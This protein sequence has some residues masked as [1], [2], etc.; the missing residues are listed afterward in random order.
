MAYNDEEY[1]KILTDIN[2]KIDT[3]TADSN[4]KSILIQSMKNAFDNKSS[5]EIE[6][7]EEFSAE[8]GILKSMLE[9]SS[10]TDDYQEFLNALKN[11]EQSFTNEI[12]NVAF[13]KKNMLQE[14]K[15]DIINVFE[16]TSYLEELYPN[17]SVEYLTEIK[18]MIS[19]S[20]ASV[21]RD[22]NGQIKTDFNS[23]VEAVGALYGN[24]QKFKGE[25]IA[26]SSSEASKL[27]ENLQ[28]VSANSSG[29]SVKLDELSEVLSQDA[30]DSKDILTILNTASG[31]IDEII[32][33]IKT[34]VENQISELNNNLSAVCSRFDS[35]LEDIK[36]SS[37]DNFSQVLEGIKTSNELIAQYKDTAS[38]LEDSLV[39][40]L[41]EF[42]E[43]ISQNNSKHT[44]ETTEKVNE[45][46]NL[47][48]D[49][50]NA[51]QTTVNPSESADF[52]NK[53]NGLETVLNENYSIYEKSLTALQEKIE[54]YIV[55]AE[56]VSS[57]ANSKLETSVLGLNEINKNLNEVYEKIK[58]SGLENSETIT[59]N[60]ADVISKFA[61]IVSVVEACKNGFDENVRTIMQDNVE[62][63]DKGLGY[64]S[65]NLKEIKDKQSENL[66]NV[67]EA[68]E[69]NITGIKEAF[70][71]V[72]SEVL[73]AVNEKSEM[74]LNEFEPVK[75]ALNKFV[76]SNFN[77]VVEDIKNQMQLSYLNLTSEL[78][79]K[80][81][82]N[83]DTFT[84]LENTYKDVVS[85][86]IALEA[87]LSSF[88]EKDLELMTSAI[89]SIDAGVKS[90]LDKSGKLYSEW[91]TF[92]ADF[93]TKIKEGMT[94]L[95]N[96]LS[97]NFRRFDKKLD[98][99]LLAKQKELYDYV[100]MISDN[101]SF[102]QLVEGANK[103]LLD[104]LEEFK[105][106]LGQGKVVKEDNLELIANVKEI[107]QNAAGVLE[108]KFSQIDQKV[109]ILAQVDNSEIIDEV[110]A[111][112]DSIEKS[113]AGL[114]SK[115][116][117][118]AISDYT[119]NFSEVSDSCGE[120][121]KSIDD[122]K[123]DIV[124]I[125]GTFDK[126][127]GKNIE[128]LLEGLHSKVDVLAMTDNSEMQ[129][130]ISGFSEK[131]SKSLSELHAKVDVLAMSEETDTSDELGDYFDKILDAIEK[132][133]STVDKLP[134]KGTSS[135]NSEKLMSTLNELQTK[136]DILAN[137]DNS[138]IYDDI[139]EIKNLIHS[140]Q[141]ILENTSDDDVS[142]KLEEIA[143][144]LDNS[145]DRIAKALELLHNKVDILALAD[146]S[147]IR[148]E[149]Q[150]IKD[151]INEQKEYFENQKDDE[152]SHELSGRLNE[153]ISDINKIEK[154][155][156]EIDLERNSQDIK[157][158]VMTAILS[159][160]DQVSFAEETEEIKDFVEE[161][162]NVINQTLLDVKK[163]LSNITN[164]G[165]D[166][167]FYSYTLQDVESDMAK[168]RLALN[169]ISANSSANEY[170]VISANIS[171]IAKSIEN[172]QN[173][174]EGKNKSKNSN[175]DF[176]KF[177]EDILSL[178][179]R[180]NKILLNY[181]ESQREIKTG[182]DR[183]ERSTQ[184]MQERLDNLNNKDF[185][186]RLLFIEQKIQESVNTT[187]VL[188]NVMMYLGEWID[189]TSEIMSSIYDKSVKAA[190]VPALLENLKNEL[191]QQSEV[192]DVIDERFK[193]QQ[194][195]I[196][197][198]EKKLEKAL[199]ML[200]D[201]DENVIT[202]KIDKI[203]THLG[204]L[205]K[206]IEKLTA[207]VD[208]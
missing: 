93:D 49:V 126:D 91:Q 150:D 7:L 128:N 171:R 170:S 54:S 206:N 81:Q 179:T 25:I 58:L 158:S 145:D 119:D 17:K 135:D 97:E 146:D 64:L 183:F 66:K 98:E 16:K 6:R 77:T 197:K 99:K 104:K 18:E 202:S 83:Q 40:K 159:V 8:L 24:I 149:I 137:E 175:S 181:D 154:N 205:T 42:V 84:K 61:D 173:N 182:L 139:D 4:E 193:E 28:I 190:S 169:E 65:E 200:S 118:L 153:L 134:I 82:V 29:L 51:V 114:H 127:G 71:H 186:K 73:A 90:G 107:L 133:Q 70:S 44:Y 156:S 110:N 165:D 122:L 184:K 187:N 103:E 74:L 27:A 78:S 161:K 22:L 152:K 14:L 172:L 53:L 36:K 121:L 106:Q 120:I 130:E 176:D 132:L 1:G 178:S 188:K 67:T 13:D 79:S 151:L 50:K 32:I 111:A 72:N 20:I 144:T 2:G 180:T 63:I 92:A 199:E 105:Q 89:V 46:V 100:S 68:V 162:T 43:E 30:A 62:F 160:T 195:K 12:K 88:S 117:I 3:L 56:Q 129:D 116:D 41:K 35:V 21:H 94:K 136:V 157:D 141:K 47:I 31:K 208:E 38:Y 177:S 166:M 194:T 10:K 147:E 15:D 75:D 109:D 168:L 125:S 55:S 185:E 48:N 11:V 5:V 57:E 174:I 131:V 204:E 113:L 52:G 164:S 191:P 198:L 102:V 37:E 59:K 33:G 123:S 155:I 138:L 39:K 167:D 101:A 148:E 76:S 196:D 45:I 34:S 124:N 60:F 85:R 163:Q 9:Q 201:Y 108:D 69:L 207:Y 112:C 189:G 140:Q 26:N 142:E 95:E 87:S 80:F 19:D 115:V 192:L 96:S 86:C 203:E 143:Q 23:L